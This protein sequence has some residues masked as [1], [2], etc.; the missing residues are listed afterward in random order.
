M[1]TIYV[2]TEQIYL[3]A[4]EKYVN[5][6]AFGVILP[7]IIL[8]DFMGNIL[9]IIILWQK[10]MYLNLV[11]SFRGLVIADYAI[12]ILLFIPLTPKSLS[13]YTDKLQDFIIPIVFMPCN[14]LLLTPEM[15]NVWITLCIA[16]DRYITISYPVKSL[17]LLTHRKAFVIIWAVT[18]VFIF[19]NLPR[20]FAIKSVKSNSIDGYISSRNTY[21]AS[22]LYLEV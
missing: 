6:I 8:F 17:R 15:T 20:I 3:I 5:F 1:I 13:K 4:G 11:I 9:T 2:E 21:S 18:S 14:F 7:I 22:H 19:Y 12:L 10:D 16:I